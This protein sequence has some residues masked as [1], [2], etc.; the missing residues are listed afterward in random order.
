[1]LEQD[2]KKAGLGFRVGE[3]L[4]GVSVVELKERLDI[5]NA[6]RERIMLEIAKKEKERAEADGIFKKH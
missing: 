2:L 3:E 6:E 5:L 4:Y 1:M